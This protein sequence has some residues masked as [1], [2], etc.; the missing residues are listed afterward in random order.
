LLNSTL[1]S[2][3]A[4]GGHDDGVSLVPSGRGDAVSL[5]HRGRDDGVSLDHSG[6]D[7]GLS[8]GCGVVGDIPVVSGQYG[9]QSSRPCLHRRPLQPTSSAAPSR[10]SSVNP[11]SGGGVSYTIF[12][13]EQGC[14]ISLQEYNNR[15]GDSG[16]AGSG[17]QQ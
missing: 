16:E 6:H 2:E 14:F 8:A 9:G 5:G 7:D 15:Y 3:S 12:D 10:S 4:S 17:G 1:D 11:P 13:C